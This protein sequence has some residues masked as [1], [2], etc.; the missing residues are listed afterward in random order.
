MILRRPEHQAGRER[1]CGIRR[2]YG[3]SAARD[4]YAFDPNDP[5]TF[6]NSTSITIFD[7]LGNL[8]IAT[9]YFIKTAASAD[10]PMNKYDTRLVINDTVITLT[11]ALLMMPASRS[12]LTGSASRP[13][14]SRMT[15]TSS[16]RGLASSTSLMIFK[17][18]F[19]QPAKISGE[20]TSFDFGEEGDKLVEI[21]RPLQFKA[22]REAGNTGSDVLGKDFP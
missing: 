6:T 20:Q 16:R 21:V 17:P 11:T 5:E 22:T 15:T 13:R 18:L 19:Q 12:L 1:E 10:D 9:V 7:D 2:R 8:T 4:G 14:P 3:P